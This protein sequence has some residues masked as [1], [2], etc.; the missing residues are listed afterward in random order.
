MG[1]FD[2][3]GDF[4]GGGGGGDTGDMGYTGGDTGGESSDWLSGLFGNGDTGTTDF[5]SLFSNYGQDMGT[6][7]PSSGFDFSSLGSDTAPVS[8]YGDMFAGMNQSAMPLDNTSGGGL[9]DLLS[10]MKSGITGMTGK[11]MPQLLQYGG[12]LAANYLGQRPQAEQTKSNLSDYL[13]NVTWTPERSNNYLNAL[14]S[15][16]AGTVGAAAG[17]QKG[18]LAEQL[19]SNGRGG[20]S[21]G[22]GSNSIDLNALNTMANTMNN[23]IQTVNQP[24][25]LSASPFMA[26]TNPM[27]QTLTGLG[28][29]MGNSYNNSNTL[30][31][32]SQLF[33]GQNN[34]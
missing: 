22:R 16:T 14:R 21:Y 20:G 15:N 26:Q 10:K 34:G 32:L 1:L 27:A 9:T 30:R 2:W 29:F 23:G 12:G 5:S 3:L 8:D 25:N 6:S 7:E 28:G 17:R 19:A 13:S 31:L 18:T 4:L 11:S 24:P 33:G